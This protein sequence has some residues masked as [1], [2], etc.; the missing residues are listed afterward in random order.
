[1]K[2]KVFAAMAMLAG[3]TTIA[4]AQPAADAAP[5]E[6]GPGFDVRELLAASVPLV[7]EPIDLAQKSDPIW[8]KGER[9]AGN[10]IARLRLRP[11]HAVVVDEDLGQGAGKPLILSLAVAGEPSAIAT[12]A[13][14]AIDRAD[15]LYCATGP[16]P[17]LAGKILCLEDKDRDGRFEQRRLGLGESGQQAEQLAMVGRAE[18][19]AAPIAYRAAAAQETPRISAS[20][21]NCAKDH[22][23]PR[24]AFSR[25]TD[26]KPGL[27]L[28][29]LVDMKIGSPEEV[30]K[31]TPEQLA[32]L[33]LMM[34]RLEAP[35]QRAEPVAPGAPGFPAA[36][37]EG[38]AAVRLDDLVVEV[39]PKKA[40]APVRLVGLAT[41]DRLYR[42]NGVAVVPLAGTVTGKQ[43]ALAI[44]HK[45]DKPVV[46][47][48]GAARIRQGE[49]QSG[50][51]VLQQEI[52][53]GYMGVLTQDTVIRT[54]LSKRSLP[55][56]TTVYGVPMSTQLTI[57]R[58]GVPMGP[59]VN[60]TPTADQVSLTWCVPVKDGDKWTAT[61]LPAQ[62]DDRYTL[63]KGQKPAFEV[64]QM[65][66]AAGTSTN[67]GP[68]PVAVQP[69]NFGKPL[70]LRLRLGNIGTTVIVVLQE[71]L[72]GDEIVHSRELWVPKAEGRISGISWGRG[73]LLLAP[74]PGKADR[75]TVSQ[76]GD[77]GSGVSPNVKHGLV[78]DPDAGDTAS[79]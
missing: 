4:G 70:S 24:F 12:A 25:Q 3:F 29:E 78:N 15:R 42:L 52:A 74:V 5:A 63:L 8:F 56:G 69:G 51:I 13:D 77:F 7:P 36:L 31:I 62:G 28:A 20:F 38:A 18:P 50:E 46:M 19:L 64:T 17:D 40:G 45:F 33:S 76:K 44:G 75:L 47:T 32:Q 73:L 22:D 39:G 55:R 66:Y 27:S 30:S 57:T 71:T 41:P 68:V 1:M 21:T 79:R 34:P 23:R 10:M 58:N 49:V 11:L 67:D 60:R 48:A 59:F 35:C 14:V 54:L 16:G 43:N 61:C 65:S 2:I 72:F 37:A 9:P 6:A 26:G 53:H